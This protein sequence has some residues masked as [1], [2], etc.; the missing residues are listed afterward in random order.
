MNNFKFNYLE[1]C[2]GCGGLSYGLKCAGLKSEVLI[3]MEKNCIKTLKKNFPNTAIIQDDMR[4]INYNK[5][6]N[7]IDIVVGGIPCQSY[8]TAGKRE[9][10]NNPDKGGLFY[11]YLR[12][13][14]EIEPKMCMI[15][16]VEGLLNINNGTVINYMISELEKRNFTVYYKVL[17]CK[18]YNIPQKRKR[19]IIIGTTMNT[20]FEFPQQFNTILTIKDALKDVPYSSG[21]EYS[22]NKKKI[23]DLV[24][25]GGCWINL[26]ENIKIEYMGNSL[27]SGGGKRGIARRLSWDEPCLTLT[28]SPCQKQTERCHPSETRPLR[29]REYAR[30][31][32]FPDTFIFE[33]SVNNI[34]KQ[35]GNA[36]PCMLGYYLGISIRK[37]LDIITNKKLILQLFNKYFI[38]N[39]ITM[40]L[41]ELIKN[42]Y[43]EK[44]ITIQENNIKR[45]NFTIDKIKKETD[46]ILYNLTDEQWL[47][48]DNKRIKDKQINNKIG[49][50]HEFLLSNCKN[51]IKCKDFDTNIKADLMK[52]DKTI[53]I[54]LKNKFNTLNSASKNET[55]KRLIDIKKL[56][57][58]SLC[59]IGI[60]NGKNNCSYKKKINDDI[61]EYCGEELLT[62]FFNDTNYY[63]TIENIISNCLSDWIKE[64]KNN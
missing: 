34:Y 31:Q 18:F 30:I 54:E 49:E 2:A 19:L 41:K 46:K 64:Y 12:I 5:Y 51:F 57:P 35:I 11:D 8:S 58:N 62:L 22:E 26:P 40:E 4:N 15:E 23:M 17:D 33:G 42:F 43:M 24:P 27:H 59:L 61:W 7:N 1:V 16:N 63:K 52:K 6:K 53:F 28:T 47:E 3:E 10:L 45:D 13:L 38:N 48:F 56:Y 29:T 39:D 37:S 14:D 50:L 21:I 60:I 36:V 44:I 25:Q 32:T 55:I 20:L 9:G